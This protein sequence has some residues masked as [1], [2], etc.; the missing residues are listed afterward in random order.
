MNDHILTLDKAMMFINY[1]EMFRIFWKDW[2]VI[3]EVEYD[4]LE[5]LVKNGT[6]IHLPNVKSLS[7]DKLELLKDFEGHLVLGFGPVR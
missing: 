5:Y 3:T 4:A 7:D 2:D 1:G 6:Y